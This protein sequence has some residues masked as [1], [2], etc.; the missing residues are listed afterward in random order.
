MVTIKIIQLEVD[1]HQS[2]ADRFRKVE[3]HLESIYCE[4]PLP[5][6]IMLPEIWGTGYF[7]FERYENEAEPLQ[8]ETFNLVA[9]WA[10]KIGSYI[11]AGSIVEREGDNLYNTAILISPNGTLA[12]CYRKVH[13]FGFQSEESA[14]LSPGEE[15]YTLKTRHGTW[16]FS[17]CYDMRF[18][19]LYREMINCDVD[20][21]FVIA[22]WP[23]A[24]LEHWEL[25]NRTRAL[26]NLSY[27]VSCNCAGKLKDCTM[28]GNSM[29]VDPWGEVVTRAGEGEEVLTAVIDP[30]KVYTVRTSFPALED[31]C[32]QVPLRP[33]S[34]GQNK[35]KRKRGKKI[36][37]Q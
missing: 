7:N 18:P 5:D 34:M 23:L 4:N 2:K 1:D 9:P 33:I 13:L 6:M 22:S 14:L 10:E 28:A 20:T 16:G 21:I 32:V 37:A 12:G 19:E 31:R 15:I 30:G 24:R 26:E 17:T 8:G 11:L 27:L 3:N 35:K 25:F 29:V 36:A